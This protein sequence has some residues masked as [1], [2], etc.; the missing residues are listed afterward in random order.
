MLNFKLYKANAIRFNLVVFILLLIGNVFAEVKENP[1]I[2]LNGKIIS[3]KL[4]EEN[5][6]HISFDL[7]VEMEFVNKSDFPTLI[8]KRKPW[9]YSKILAKSAKDLSIK[10][11]LYY[12]YLGY[13]NDIS[14]KW[15]KF[16]ESIDI[17]APPQK[18]FRYILPNDAWKFDVETVIVITKTP[19]KE[20]DGFKIDD[21]ANNKIDWTE[22]KSSPE[23]WMQLELNFWWSNIEP[24]A[25][26]EE[27]TFGKKLRKQWGKYGYLWLDDVKSSPI[28]IDF[29]SVITTNK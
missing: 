8:S 16:R 29:K 11:S 1:P 13:G 19:A 17:A 5:E 3:F 9:L 4:I 28:P 26:G 14:P 22:I 27:N 20:K 7:T 12:S 21:G 10:N 15:E 24:L 25:T 6:T 18:H 2:E 23:L